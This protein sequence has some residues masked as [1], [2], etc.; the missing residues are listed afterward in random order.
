[1]FEELRVLNLH[2][3]CIDT[4]FGLKSLASHLTHL[5]SITLHGNPVT[6]NKH[7]RNYILHTFPNLKKFDFGGVVKQ[8][9][10]SAKSWAFTFRKKLNPGQFEDTLDKH[11]TTTIVS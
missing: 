9:R 11:T 3:N 5:R 2:G 10:E 7:Y 4:I 8:D 1:P 6:E